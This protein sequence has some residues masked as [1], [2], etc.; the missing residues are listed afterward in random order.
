MTE[1]KTRKSLVSKVTLIVT[2][3]GIVITLFIGVFQGVLSCISNQNQESEAAPYF[4]ASY[5][6]V[7]TADNLDYAWSLKNTGGNIRSVKCRYVEYLKSYFEDESKEITDEK[8]I[9]IIIE[10]E[11][12]KYN[13]KTKSIPIIMNLNTLMETLELT[14]PILLYNANESLYGKYQEKQ[15]GEHYPSSYLGFEY[16]HCLV[17]EYKDYKHRDK[18]LVLEILQ[19]PEL[20]N[21]E[22]KERND[23]PKVP[24]NATFYLGR[25]TKYDVGSKVFD[26]HHIKYQIVDGEFSFPH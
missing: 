16:I 18:Q 5:E 11:S 24:E 4:V 25:S 19:D 9:K 12:M 6:K 23:L 7:T 10:D 14:E 8:W 20:E 1:K 3:I 22:I 2:I 13:S 21:Y 15:T 17:I 26:Q